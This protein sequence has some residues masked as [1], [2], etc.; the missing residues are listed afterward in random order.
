MQQGVLLVSTGLHCTPFVSLSYTI[1]PEASQILF[2]DGRPAFVRMLAASTFQRSQSVSSAVDALPSVFLEGATKC[3]FSYR[4]YL[5]GKPTNRQSST[6]SVYCVRH[7][8]DV[9]DLVLGFGG[10]I[11]TLR[12]RVA[13]ETCPLLCTGVVCSFSNLNG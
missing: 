6:R 9:A 5:Y 4:E 8:M 1:R 3:P 7:L 2:A 12:S 13:K 11:C 10:Y